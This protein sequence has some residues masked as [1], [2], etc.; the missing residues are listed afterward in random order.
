[1]KIFVGSSVPDVFTQ[2]LQT[3]GYEVWQTLTPKG[4]MPMFRQLSRNILT[5]I[6]ILKGIHPGF[7]KLGFRLLRGDVEQIWFY[8]LGFEQEVFKLSTL[9][10]EVKFKFF[11]QTILFD[12]QMARLKVLAGEGRN[13]SIYT[14][15][16]IDSRSIVN[17]YN[18][19]GYLQVVPPLPIM[20]GDYF[21]S[22]QSKA[23]RYDFCII[24]QVQDKWFSDAQ[25]NQSLI[26]AF[27]RFLLVI[28]KA[29]KDKE[30]S[31]AVQLR[32]QASGDQYVD[33]EK[34]FFEARLTNIARLSFI[35]ANT[36]SFASYQTMLSSEVVLSLYST[37]LLEA[38]VLRKK[39]VYFKFYEMISENLDSVPKIVTPEMSAGEI[40]E[41]LNNC[42]LL[43]EEAY[44]G[45][46][47]LT[48]NYKSAIALDKLFA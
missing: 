14:L 16:Q 30:I 20:I 5:F 4:N 33:E 24:S 40:E 7:W 22:F 43:S 12:R 28:N 18:F 8:K 25:P 21:N 34:R 32:P 44:F 46:Y 19:K 10:P 2:F 13:C 48:A 15:S 42:L 45:N 38:M 6:R 39:A 27:N 3:R 29:L 35:E 26:N 11:L 9:F 41:L 31:V 17:H 47:E 23:V 36:R 1:M 37:M